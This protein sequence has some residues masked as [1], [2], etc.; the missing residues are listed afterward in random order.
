VKKYIDNKYTMAAR[1]FPATNVTEMKVN[2]FLVFVLSAGKETGSQAQ[3]MVEIS[4]K[5]AVKELCNFI[6]KKIL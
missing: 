3:L 4:T 1:A 5:Q 2:L 6:C